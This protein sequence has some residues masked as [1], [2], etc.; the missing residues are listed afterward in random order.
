MQFFLNSLRLALST[1]WGN[2]VHSLLT[3]LGIIIGVTT[4]VGMMGVIEGMKR[5]VNQDMMYLGVN[6]FEISL[7]QQGVTLRSTHPKLGDELTLEDMRAIRELSPSSGAVSA[8]QYMTNQK[9]S[10]AEN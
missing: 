2:P 9:I 8:T 6:T 1:F 4:T 5:K 3:V 10:S 7:P